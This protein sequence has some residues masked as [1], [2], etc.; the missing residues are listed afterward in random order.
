[1]FND[2][3]KQIE[4]KHGYYDKRSCNLIFIFILYNTFMSFVAQPKDQ[5]KKVLI[6]IDDHI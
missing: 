1:M 5:Q 2:H 3:K 6:R 4:K